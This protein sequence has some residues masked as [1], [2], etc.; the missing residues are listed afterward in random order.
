MHNKCNIPKKAKLL[1]GS[2]GSETIIAI[3]PKKDV[4]KYFPLII[5]KG[6]PKKDIKY[7]VQRFKTEINNLKRL[8]KQFIHTNKTPHLVKLLNYDYCDKIPKNIFNDCIENAI[9]LQSK[10]EPEPKCDYIYK[11][12]N[13]IGHGMYVAK[14][15]YCDSQ[16]ND[17]LEKIIKKPIVQIKSFLDKLLFQIIFTLEIIRQKYPNY[18]HNDFFIR[19]ILTTTNNVSKNKYNRYVLHNKIY[20]I[21]ADGLF[22]KIGDFSMSKFNGYSNIYRDWFNIIYDLYNGANHGSKSLSSLTKNFKK[23]QF[24]KKYFNQ[25]MNVKIIDKIIKN[26]K[27]KYL[28]RGWNIISDPKIVKLFKLQKPSKILLYFDKLYKSSD[29]YEINKIFGN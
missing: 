18:I 21:P 13:I 20:D 15:E 28:D 6:T 17:A 10:H 9:F 1:F 5:K 2:G 29:E 14:L 26:G 27:K 3:T 11:D 25:F 16:L 24:L 8:T 12:S 19:N 22:I 7:F 4:Y 23:Q